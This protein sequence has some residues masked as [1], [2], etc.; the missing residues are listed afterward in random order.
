M[1]SKKLIPFMLLALCF[2]GCDSNFYEMDKTFPKTQ[3]HVKGDGL[4]CNKVTLE[5]NGKKVNRNEFYHG[6]KVTINFID[7][8]GFKRKNQR[9]YPHMDITI[10]N[11]SG[12]IVIDSKNVLGDKGTKEYPFKI[13][14]FFEALFE[15]DAGT[16]FE[17]L[18]EIKD[19][20]G[21]GTLTATM[22]FTVVPNPN[23]TVSKKGADCEPIAIWD[24]ASG[25]VLT[26]KYIKP[27]RD[28][29]ILFNQ[30]KGIE[31]PY[32]P[33]DFTDGNG[34]VIFVNDNLFEEV[35]PEDQK[36]M[37]QQFSARFTLTPNLV[38]PITVRCRVEDLRSENYLE[39]S[40][41]V[42]VRK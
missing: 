42:H 35:T 31:T 36:K 11:D 24:A 2:V 26:S 37:L 22:P 6:E 23:I 34:K 21:N 25:T 15:E 30:V 10:K 18:I 7:A 39:V 28:Y 1:T 16:S 27:N 41:K 8:Q 38:N 17:I 14:A 5:I 29:H 9:A 32:V 13:S 19:K 3:L 33:L 20:K 12:D 4:K 40:T